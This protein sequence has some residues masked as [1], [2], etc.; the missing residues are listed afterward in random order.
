MAGFYQLVGGLTAATGLVLRDY[1]AAGATSAGRSP[2][3][4]FLLQCVEASPKNMNAMFAP[5]GRL[6][7]F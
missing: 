4:E 3:M 1:M 6:R 2:L 7:R 5:L